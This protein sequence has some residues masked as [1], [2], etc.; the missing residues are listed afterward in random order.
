MLQVKLIYMCP[1]FTGRG[2]G[3][4][5]EE[6]PRALFVLTDLWLPSAPGL[7]PAKSRGAEEPVGHGTARVLLFG[8]SDIGRQSSEHNTH[9]LLDSPQ[10]SFRRRGMSC[11]S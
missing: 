10:V 3:G 8:A 9:Y 5:D 1:H 4:Q 11:P 2:A 6:D 7:N